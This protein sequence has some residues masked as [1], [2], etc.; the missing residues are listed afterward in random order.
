[1]TLLSRKQQR[2][3]KKLQRPKVTLTWRRW[4]I[5]TPQR[6]DLVPAM[7]RRLLS[8]KTKTNCPISS[9]LLRPNVAEDALEKDKLRKLKQKFYYGRSANDLQDLQR[10]DV[11]RMQPFRLNEKTWRKEKELKPLGRRS[12]VVESNGQLGDT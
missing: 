11:V 4:L 6:K 1:M 7:P 3:S 5:V 2:S 12:Y 10:D 9:N 8:R